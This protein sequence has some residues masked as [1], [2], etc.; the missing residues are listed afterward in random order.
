M[1]I[2]FIKGEYLM[3][4]GQILLILLLVLI[5]FGFLLSESIHMYEQLSLS[6]TKIAD[7]EGELRVIEERYQTSTSE[8][9]QLKKQIEQI[10]SEK[11]Q[12]Q[13]QFDNLRMENSFLRGQNLQL[14]WE[15]DQLASASPILAYVVRVS[16]SNLKLAAFI[17]VLPILAGLTLIVKRRLKKR[18]HYQPYTT[19]K[20]PRLPKGN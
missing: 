9:E 10:I 18:P 20:Q 12:L 1:L 8:N 2:E 13:L 11:Q 14:K 7:L 16:S 17:P 15:N 3:R 4:A 5:G 6:Q 19:I